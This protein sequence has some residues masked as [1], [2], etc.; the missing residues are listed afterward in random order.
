VDD[1]VAADQQVLRRK[2][3]NRDQIESFMQNFPAQQDILE[4]DPEEL[5]AHVLRYMTRPQAE[6]N[7]FNFLVM[8]YPGAIAER[9]MEAWGW[10]EREGFI[11]H[12]PN[13]M[14]GLSFFVTRSGQRVAAEEN[15]EAWRKAA[16]FPEGLDPIIMRA[17]KPL[18]TR[19]DYDTAVFRA[20]KEVEIRI[21]RKHPSLANEYGV[22]LMNKAFGDKNGVLMTGNKKDRQSARELFAGAFGLCRNPS[23]HHEIKFDDPREVVDM[24]CFANQLL[25]IV[26]RI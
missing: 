9:F 10:L 2:K 11:A 8:V 7:R 25:R 26:D 6:T 18:F 23:A 16:I 19:G 17:V 22:D 3:V 5:G 15:F 20:F 4:M 24:I 13:D 12:R 14:H 21:R 1:A